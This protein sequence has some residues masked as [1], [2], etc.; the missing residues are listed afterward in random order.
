MSDA[1]DT[2]ADTVEA[3][4]A[5]PPAPEQS[6]DDQK[7]FTQTELEKIIEARLTRERAK[8]SD[9]EQIKA[10]AAELA[11]I[12][13]AEKTELQR[14][15]EKAAEAEKRAAEAEFTA[16]RNKVAAQKQVPPGSLT[17]SSEEELIASADELIAWRDQAGKT[18]TTSST[19][20]AKR[21]PS[22]G[23]KSGATRTES[24]NS[25]PKARAAEAVRLLRS[26]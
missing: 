15:Q 18:T 2:A 8:F 12:R 19:P 22:G 20:A 5:S 9:Y 25:D 26:R 23:L 3:A 10:D 7:T 14:W 6:G 11:K 17:G 24:I 1:P 21:P 4:D 16:L 13:D